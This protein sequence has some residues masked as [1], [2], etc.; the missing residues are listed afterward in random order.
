MQTKNLTKTFKDKIAVN[1]VSMNVKKGDIYGF[2]GRN[3][4][5][6]STFM[7]MICG[8]IIPSGGQIK[9]FESGNLTK[10]REKIGSIIET[11]SF[12]PSMSVKE[13]LIYYSIITGNYKLNKINDILDKVGLLESADKKAKILSL[14]MKQRLAIAIA[15][16]STADFL[17]LD[18]PINGLD[19]TGI[20]EIRELLKRLNQENNITIVISSHILGELSKIAT[21]YG[22]IDNGILIDEF[23]QKESIARCKKYL[24]LEVDN[25]ESAYYILREKI[26]LNNFKI[27]DRNLIHIYDSFERISDINKALVMD[28]INVSCVNKE[29]KDF[30]EYVINLMGGE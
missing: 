3:G 8:L 24:K 22:V 4:A 29:G 23:D 2:I 25:S 6:K 9:L 16:I 15:L 28:G 26:G 13:N 7:K 21:R 14:G 11:P 30:E 18:E 12:Y 27:M 5:G 20:K 10:G 17:I 1:C 19:P